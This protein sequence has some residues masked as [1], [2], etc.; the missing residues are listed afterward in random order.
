M[1]FVYNG[2][3][4]LF[5][6]EPSN[7]VWLCRPP[8]KNSTGMVRATTDYEAN[9]GNSG[10][11]NTEEEGS[12]NPYWKPVQEWKRQGVVLGTTGYCPGRQPYLSILCP[13]LFQTPK[14]G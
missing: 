2:P 12:L 14:R 6:A 10:V 1:R 3:I 8:T 5:L 4:G 7:D 9:L 11:W 13:R